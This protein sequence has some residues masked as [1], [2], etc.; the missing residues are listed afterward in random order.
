LFQANVRSRGAGVFAQGS[1]IID[2][3]IFISNIDHDGGGAIAF[4]GATQ[5]THN[6]MYDNVTDDD[7]GGMVYSENAVGFSITNNTIVGN[8]KNAGGIGGVGIVLLTAGP[9]TIENN[10][11]TMNYGPYGIL[12][13]NNNGVTCAYNDAWQNAV[14]NYLGVGAG[15]GA[16]SANPLFNDTSAYDF[17]LSQL[18]PCIDAGDP[19]IQFHDPDGTPNDIG[20]VFVWR[21]GAPIAYA[22]NLG[23]ED[24]THVLNHTPRFF[25]SFLDTLPTAQSSY[26]VEVGADTDWATAESWATS[27]VA[28]SDTFVQYAGVPLVDG[29]RY[30]ARIRV[31]DGT[32]WGSW[33]PFSFR[34]NSEPTIPLLV[35]PVLDTLSRYNGVVLTVANAMD[36]E[37]DPL[38][39]DFELY[40]DSSL[41]AL[42][43]SQG[44]V[45]QQV[46]HTISST[47]PALLIDHRYWWR[48]RAH[49]GFEYSA[50][51]SSA[52]FI[53]RGGVIAVPAM[54]PT[55]ALA[56]GE[57]TN[58]D[59]VLLAWGDYAEQINPNGKNLVFLGTSP[60]ESTRVNPPS[61]G[62]DVVR[63]TNGENSSTIVRGLTIHGAANA[64]GIY[65]SG[66][67]P[68][69][70]DNIIE[71]NTTSGSSSGGG[72][73]IASGSPFIRGN[74]I[75]KNTADVKGGGIFVANGASATI[76]SNVILLNTCTD[77][78]GA[79]AKLGSG[80]LNVTYNIIYGN[81]NHDDWGGAVY[82]EN[83]P[84]YT[85][86]N[87]TIV[88]NHT[89]SGNGAGITSLSPQGGQIKNNII[90]DNDG[91]YGVYVF[92]GSGSAPTVAYNDSWLNGTTGY[93]GVTAG[94][95]SISSDPLLCDTSL[96]DFG[97]QGGSPCL[98]AGEG[99]LSIGAKGVGCSFL[100]PQPPTI[101]RIGIDYPGDSVHV[102]D[103][104]P[105]LSWKYEDAQGRPHTKS[106]IEVGTDPDWSVAEK[107]QPA[108]MIGPDTSVVYAGTPL[109]DGFVYF[110]R[111]RVFNDTLW[112]NWVT[113]LFRM[114][115]VPTAPGPASPAD[116]LIVMTGRPTLVVSNSL[117]SEGDPCRY[118]F[119]VYRDSGSTQLAAYIS[120][121]VQ[122]AVQTSWKVDSLTS[123]NQRHW[124]RS[125]AS[126]GYENGSWSAVRS[127]W[128]DAFNQ[129]PSA[130]QLIS[131]PNGGT[132]TDLTPAFVWAKP[133]DP[134]PNPTA[135]YKL[136]IGLDPGFNFK[137]E[138]TGITDTTVEWAVPLNVGQTYWWKI[139]ANDGRGG[140]SV[141]S[142]WSFIVVSPC[143]CNCHGDPAC[144]G[145]ISDILD[146]VNTINVAFR[147]AAAIV[148]PNAQ[149]PKSP[150][151]MNCSGATDVID[152][153]KV[154]NV[155]FRGANV[156]TEY[157]VPCG[158]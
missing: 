96:L 54:K 116:N 55:I 128:V 52:S 70:L 150:T 101:S 158:I 154:I 91:G 136:T 121:V 122:G 1:I 94:S 43:W 79:M 143:A 34:M 152:V 146:V 67:S 10:I 105:V 134:D 7:W 45:S 97:L 133:S 111:V 74:V 42:A 81:V 82:I 151:D 98:V 29:A 50:W 124:W 24:S 153:V 99:G 110:V 129:A 64:N 32:N 44:G 39:Y 16:I 87:N 100:G 141:S 56:V 145:V 144:D 120:G 8:K 5:I 25:W 35:G 109:G 77:G 126:D 113:A 78:G 63:I 26:E 140:L 14:S 117:D 65:I 47:L 123:E 118:D 28:S 149:C 156:A 61:S 38:Q 53:T 6:V 12:V 72:I 13:Y 22:I 30:Q 125:R 11:V 135:T 108:V 9:G 104:T 83:T 90:A 59:T 15:P 131:V 157:C 95:G 127:F 93:F 139:E 33:R 18:S 48:S 36:A 137:S 112:S 37:D 84:D 103:A 148:D 75:R 155:A 49:D 130:V 23:P 89:T 31:N 85:I 76:D 51:S 58:G 92:V 46:G 107:W 73:Y 66:A 69:I 102:I 142:V 88:G 19:N 4:D 106:Q 132:T 71:Q 57:A 80:S 27:E 60:P 86:R 62:L 40:S 2:S 114:N 147:G 17:Q 3:N 115:S 138:L 119:E 21:G 68:T 41:G 20:A